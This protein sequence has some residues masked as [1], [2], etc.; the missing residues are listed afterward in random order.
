VGWISKNFAERVGMVV[1]VDGDG[2]EVGGVGAAAA[3]DDAVDV[4]SLGD[5]SSSTWSF[6]S[7][8]LTLQLFFVVS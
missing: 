3:A 4:E 5:G 7:S 8:F 1:V 6:P 2:D